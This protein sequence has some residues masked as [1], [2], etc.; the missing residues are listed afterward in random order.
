MKKKKKKLK[1]SISKNQRKTKK[2]VKK[3]P[4]K[5]NKF[6]PKNK[7]V[8]RINNRRKKKNKKPKKLIKL[9]LSKKISKKS[10][11]IV[12]K[13]PDFL[14]KV[15]NFQNSLKPEFN[16]RLNFGFE[17]YIQAFF[18]KIADTISQYKIL[19]KDEARR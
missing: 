7:S 8:K 4:K 12:S 10:K 13:K 6:K 3:I 5:S 11:A 17:K 2:R 18:D 14:L 16:F 9:K 1:K 15:V 19:K